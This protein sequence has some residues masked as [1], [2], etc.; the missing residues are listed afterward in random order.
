MTSIWFNSI[1][2]EIL[3]DHDKSQIEKFSFSNICLDSNIALYLIDKYLWKKSEY[4]LKELWLEY[5]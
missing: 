5:C 2:N 3:D 4:E 1:K